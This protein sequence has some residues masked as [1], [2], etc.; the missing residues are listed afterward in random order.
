MRV[1]M[2]PV[3]IEESGIKKQSGKVIA[4]C[5]IAFLAWA[6]T[7][8]ID[9]GTVVHGSVVVLGSRKAVQHPQGGVVEKIMVREGDK[10]QQG[11]IVLQ[12]NPLQI[13]ANLQQSEYEFIQALAAHSRLIAE[14]NGQG[15]IVWEP[16][17]DKFA[18]QTQVAQAKRLQQALFTSRQREIK[19]AEAIY[20]QKDSGLRQQLEE[21][22]NIMALRRSQLTPLQADAQSVRRLAQG[23]F[24][25]GAR[26]NEAERSAIRHGEDAVIATE[27]HIRRNPWQSVG[28]AAGVGLVIGVLL[29]RR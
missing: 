1:G 26:A 9:S 25:P 21:K 3:R 7:A 27:Q 6:M 13:E 28:I 5:F 20:A 22:N 17:L 24:V 14:R 4:I 8:P 18:S 23:G 12:I 16:D 10:V 15:A 2:E 29:A 19:A 11:D